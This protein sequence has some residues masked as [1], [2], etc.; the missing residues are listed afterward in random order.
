[1]KL[2]APYTGG[3]LRLA[4]TMVAI[5][6]VFAAALGYWRYASTAA[7]DV[8]SFDSARAEPNDQE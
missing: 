4:L 5:A 8:M 3:L 1:M 2:M 6:A 7:R